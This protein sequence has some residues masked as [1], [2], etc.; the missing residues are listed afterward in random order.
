[1]RADADRG[2]WVRAD[3][4]LTSSPARV[5]QVA[6]GVGTL[7]L[8]AV[9]SLQA[10]A[11]R[12][13]LARYATDNARASVLRAEAAEEDRR[14]DDD[15]RAA[16]DAERRAFLRLVLAIQSGADRPAQQAAFLALVA[17]YQR[18]DEIR[19]LTAKTR[20]D[21]VKKRA[22]NPIPVPALTCN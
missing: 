10:T 11:T 22:D 5:V 21:N 16:A 4:V 1:M 15:D 18:G 8:V 7:L 12:D 17:T 9:L 13:C 19:V 3:R 14:A 6:L 2:W 20:A